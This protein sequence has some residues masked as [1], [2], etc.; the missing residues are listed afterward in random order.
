MKKNNISKLENIICNLNITSYDEAKE[1]SKIF[2][3]EASCEY[4]NFRKDFFSK[5][6]VI[7]YIVFLGQN[8][9]HDSIMIRNTIL[10]LGH[11]AGMYHIYPDLSYDFIFQH[12]ED[13]DKNIKLAIA[14]FIFIFPQFENYKHK[15]DYILGIPNISPQK[16]SREH[17]IT[18]I[19]RES[20]NIIPLK[21]ANKI[22]DIIKGFMNKYSLDKDTQIMYDNLIKTICVLP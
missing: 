12:I 10:T 1:V 18:C 7:Q 6:N 11:I 9:N 2:L 15:W 8:N 13:S 4:T 16:I 21:Y 22:A 19:L 14:R 20:K 17:F 3:K 5:Q